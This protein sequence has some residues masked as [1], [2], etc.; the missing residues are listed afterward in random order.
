MARRYA[1]LHIHIGRAGNGRPIKVTAARDLTF[2]NIARECATRKGIDIAGIVDCSAPSV[3]KDIDDLVEAG[4]MVEQPDGG[5]RYHEKTTLL[6]GSELETVEVDGCS[7][8]QIAY[9]GQRDQM[10]A[11]VERLRAS[12]KN[13]D[14]SSQ[15]CRMPARD[16]LLLTKELGGMFVPAHAFTPHKGVYG[17]CVRRLADMFGD[18]LGQLDALE[19]GLSADSMLADRLA[20]LTDL[21]FISN[22]DAHSLP[23]IA[24]EYNVLE[25]EGTSFEE[26]RLALHREQGRRVIENYGLDPRLGKYHRTYCLTCD[27]I[28]VA[29]PPI[30]TCPSCEGT[31][32]VRGVLD[33][34]VEIEDYAEPRAPAH[35]P[36]YHYQIPLQ[37]LPGVG[38]VTLGKLLN[39]F[40]TEMAVLHETSFDDL[41]NTVGTK[42]ARLIIQAR[43]GTLPLRAGGGGHYGKAATEAADAQ[44]SLGW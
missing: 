2:G 42:V 20:E 3:M 13:L 43:E 12:V 16:L 17:A 14:L 29:A 18:D 38:A 27:S 25:V 36:T 32:V 28:A 6:L 41:E 37:F 33:R 8:H 39:R 4:E 5:L 24:R 10:R 44:M 7:S 9:F 19:L 40:G 21:S 35:R 34:I 31:D 15:H 23:K 26:V 22:S 1:D 30:T 11:F